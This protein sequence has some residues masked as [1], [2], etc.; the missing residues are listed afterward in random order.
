MFDSDSGLEPAKVKLPKTVIMMVEKGNLVMAIKTLAADEN[1]SMD[2]AKSRIDAYEL[3]LKNQQ[4]QKL[5]SIANKQ[6][7]PSQ[8]MNFDRET[9]EDDTER[10]I[11]SKVKSTPTEQSF[12]SLQEGVDSQLNDLGYKKPLLPYWAKRLLIIAIIMAG[13]FW[14]MWRVFG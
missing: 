4:Q 14:I 1:I 12:Q 3:A 8:A 11:K 6:G 9:V 2:A 7:I 10:L 13:L 5:N